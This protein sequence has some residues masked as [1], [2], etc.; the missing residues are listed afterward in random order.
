MKWKEK[1][2]LDD[3][4][5]CF[6]YSP[7]VF[8]DQ[9]Y[10]MYSC[11]QFMV[12]DQ[13]LIRRTGGRP[14][15]F[16]FV[17]EGSLIIETERETALAR[18]NEAVLLNGEK[19]H[20]YRCEGFCRF[21]FFHYSGKDSAEITDALIAENGSSVFTFS[22]ENDFQLLV[23][24]TI[25]NCLDHDGWDP[26]DLSAMIY[27]VFCVL[28]KTCRGKEISQ[29][30][31]PVR[32]AREYVRQNILE[33]IT[34]K[35]MAA[36]VG[37]SPY[38]LSRC[39]RKDLGISPIRYV[40]KE[41]IKY[42]RTVLTTSNSSVAEIAESLSYSSAASFINAFRAET[43]MSPTQYRKQKSTKPGSFRKPQSEEI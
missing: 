37:F 17:T 2:T 25:L 22:K 26:F 15:L 35:E 14:N 12:N 21:L 42:A 38:Y 43:G 11:G 31:R 41:K 19:P 32:K 36:A 34:L 29:S 7:E 20:L 13:Y 39:F 9:F 10:S 40:S 5:I 27:Y 6:L 33:K 8:R 3:T 24:P 1:G 30:K 23:F 28:K 4:R 16:I 18:E